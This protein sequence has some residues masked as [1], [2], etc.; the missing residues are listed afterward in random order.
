[1]ADV[2]GWSPTTTTKRAKLYSHIGDSARRQAMQ[3]TRTVEIDPGS[4]AFPFDVGR[5]KEA[6]VAN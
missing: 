5:G 6:T 3:T 1:V 2:L 4:F